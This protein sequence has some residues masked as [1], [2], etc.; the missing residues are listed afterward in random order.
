MARHGPPRL[1]RRVSRQRRRAGEPG[2]GARGPEA[3]RRDGE[4]EGDEEE[5]EE[6]MSG[7]SSMMTGE[8]VKPVFG[9]S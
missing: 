8:V 7:K 9:F 3:A 6:S 1:P 2:A 4:R 5:G